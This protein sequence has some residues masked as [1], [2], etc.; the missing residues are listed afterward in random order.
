MAL[1]ERSLSRLVSILK[2]VLPLAAIGIL[3]TLFLLSKR[4]DPVSTIP[5]TT[6]DLQDAARSERIVAPSFAG[7]TEAG[8][9]IAFTAE[10][11]TPTGDQRMAAETLSARIDLTSGQQITFRAD[12]GEIDRKVD[13][14]HLSGGVTITSSTGYRIETEVLNAGLTEIRASSEG[15]IRG[16]GPLGTFTAGQMALTS[17]GQKDNAY[18]LFT[19]GVHLIYEPAQGSEDGNAPAAIQDDLPDEE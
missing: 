19:E 1:S 10:T 5:F 12:G 2:V 11:A 6:I 18:L 8:D 16:N 14:A 13:N 4:T 7:A 9:L 17:R 3:S 15:E